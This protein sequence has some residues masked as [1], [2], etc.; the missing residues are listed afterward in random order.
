MLAVSDQEYY[1]PV[2]TG[3]GEATQWWLYRKNSD[4]VVMSKHFTYTVINHF[5][6]SDQPA[7]LSFE[8]QA[9]SVKPK[10]RTLRVFGAEVCNRFTRVLANNTTLRMS[11]DFSSRD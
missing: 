8:F 9:S 5:V 6:H 3:E 11:I 2:K 7:R 1:L 4:D 10:P